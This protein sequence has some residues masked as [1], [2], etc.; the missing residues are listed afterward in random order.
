VFLSVM[1]VVICT[2]GI[3]LAPGL[4]TDSTLNQWYFATL[5][6]ISVCTFVLIIISVAL[7]CMG[8]RWQKLNPSP[9]DEYP[10]LTGKRV[11]IARN[12][13]AAVLVGLSVWTLFNFYSLDVSF[14]NTKNQINAGNDPSYDAFER[15][16]SG[17]FNAQY[18]KAVNN[19]KENHWIWDRVEKYCGYSDL[20]DDTV[21][22]YEDQCEA[23]C[24]NTSG[25]CRT[26]EDACDDD[27]KDCPYHIC[28]KGL[29]TFME[30]RLMWAYYVCSVTA[31]LAILQWC[32]SLALMCYHHKAS[33]VEILEKMGAIRKHGKVAK[34]LVETKSFGLAPKGEIKLFWTSHEHHSPEHAARKQKILS[35]DSRRLATHLNFH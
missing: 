22:I 6:T 34:G 8:I 11:L 26:S 9:D 21:S 23:D 33:F 35:D 10:W 31:L 1:G 29:L 19:C 12:F 18:F 4:A 25:T 27:K 5:S 28:R 2:F 24:G 20:D 15:D 17:D 16:F 30:D 13:L 3:Y 7:S 14:R 32:C